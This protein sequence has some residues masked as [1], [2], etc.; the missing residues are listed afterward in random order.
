MRKCTTGNT[1]CL[2]DLELGGP[3]HVVARLLYVIIGFITFKLTR[4][5]SGTKKKEKQGGRG[6]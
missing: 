1:A 4:D 3:C 5:E 2:N 6:S